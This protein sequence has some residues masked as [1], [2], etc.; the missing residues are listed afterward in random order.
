MSRRARRGTLV[1]ALLPLVGCDQATKWAAKETLEGRDPHQ[2]L[3]ALLDLRYAENTDIAFNLLRWIPEALRMR[4]L[5]IFGAAALAALLVAVW[6]T[7]GGPLVRAALVLIA[8]GAAGNYLDRLVRGYVIDFVH[9]PHWP[10]F[11]VADVYVVA[12]AGLLA[13]AGWRSRADE[14]RHRGRDRVGGSDPQA[15]A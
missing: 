3:G 2:V 1:A 9:V 5:L 8:A 4:A 6:R 15:R 10:V 12:G 11:N 14:P 13:M 7:R